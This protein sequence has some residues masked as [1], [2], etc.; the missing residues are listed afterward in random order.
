MRGGDAADRPRGARRLLAL[1]LAGALAAGGIGCATMAA[2]SLEASSSRELYPTVEQLDD[3]SYVLGSYD[4]RRA[5]G[6]NTQLVLGSSELYPA[7]GVLFHPATMLAGDATGVDAM[8]LGRPG[9]SD[10]WQ[11]V[12]VGALAG[13]RGVKR[14]VL[15]PSLLWFT[16]GRNPQSDYP[17]I[18]SQGAYDAFMAQR[19]LSDRTKRAATERLRRDGVPI[20]SAEGPFGHA[21]TRLDASIAEAAQSLHRLFARTPPAEDAPRLDIR[22]TG[23]AGPSSSTGFG[24][25]GREPRWGELYTEAREASERAHADSELGCY[26]SW[27]EGGYRT[28][29]RRAREWAEAGPAALSAEELEDFKLVLSVCREAGVEACVLIQPVNGFVYDETVYGREVRQRFYQM[30][31]D[32][33]DEAGIAYADLSSH[34]YDDLFFRDDNHPSSVGAL[35]Y[36][37]AIWTFLAQGAPETAPL[38]VE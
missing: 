18:F 28:F 25:A 12:E 30:I 10:V 24:S 29:S 5:A 22:P 15:V 20:P 3:Y 34:E 14:V 21:A 32:A 19:H 16:A 8:V 2:S 36:S 4:A 31:R 26:R 37:R 11:A 27:M 9:C 17:G 33:C 1:A 35:Y 7:P 6:Y 23:E 13:D 38:D